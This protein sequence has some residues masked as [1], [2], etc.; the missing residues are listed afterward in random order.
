MQYKI[1]NEMIHEIVDGKDA[2]DLVKA[3]VEREQEEEEVVEEK[4]ETRVEKPRW[5]LE[6]RDVSTSV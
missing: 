3:F 4:P 1:A 5:F 2:E 6:K